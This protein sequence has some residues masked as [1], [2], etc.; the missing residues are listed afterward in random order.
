MLKATRTKPLAAEKNRPPHEMRLLRVMPRLCANSTARS[1]GSTGPRLGGLGLDEILHRLEREH[2][3]RL[4]RRARHA[5]A[6]R[7]RLHSL[8]RSP[9]PILAGLL[10]SN[11]SPIKKLQGAIEADVRQGQRRTGGV[12]LGDRRPEA[13]KAVIRHT[14][15]DDPHIAGENRVR[16][17]RQFAGEDRGLRPAIENLIADALARQRNA[18]DGGQ[19]CAAPSADIGLVRRPNGRE[20]HDIDRGADILRLLR[21]RAPSAGAESPQAGHDSRD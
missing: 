21:W 10:R 2:L 8:L 9:R 6:K 16:V 14:W 5:E 12:A 11:L 15:I 1:A 4:L 20:R 18:D 13:H 19:R 3:A 7:L 17:A